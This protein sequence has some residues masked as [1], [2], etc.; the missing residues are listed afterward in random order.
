[1]EAL[2]PGIWRRGRLVG[3]HCRR[4]EVESAVR[5]SI[6]SPAPHRPDESLAAS[7]ATEAPE[8]E[9]GDDAPQPTR[10]PCDEEQEEDDGGRSQAFCLRGNAEEHREYDEAPEKAESESF[11]AAAQTIVRPRR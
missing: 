6:G 11:T 5:A 7:G 1:M 3:G 2:L 9:L 10:A 8:I 4:P